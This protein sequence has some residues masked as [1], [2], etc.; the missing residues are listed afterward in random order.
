MIAKA[1]R[2]RIVEQRIAKP[3]RAETVLGHPYYNAPDKYYSIEVTQPFYL[4][5]I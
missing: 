5:K 3:Y 2:T 4:L 1:L